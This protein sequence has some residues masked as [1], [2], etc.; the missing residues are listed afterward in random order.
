MPWTPLSQRPWCPVKGNRPIS[1]TCQL[2]RLQTIA[3]SPWG[4]WAP[5]KPQPPANV[6]FIRPPWGGPMYN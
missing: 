1:S 5:Q 2:G 3:G 4:P 6:R